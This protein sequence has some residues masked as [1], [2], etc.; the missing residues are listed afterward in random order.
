[1]IEPATIACIAGDI[2]LGSSVTQ[3]ELAPAAT[4]SQQTRQQRVTMFGS[5]VMAAARDVVTDHP[6]DRLRSLPIEITLVC[7]GLQRQPLIAWLP[8]APGVRADTVIA[9]ND[10][11]PPIGVGA[12]VDRVGDHPVDAG[13][14]WSTPDDV[15][16]GWPCRQIQVVL[17]EPKQR[18]TGA[19]EFHHLGEDQG[20][21]LL[22]TPVGIFLEPIARLHEADWCRHD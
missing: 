5:A 17:V 11:G 12:T 16:V 18:L 22:N 2:V 3:R 8:A 7:V 13:V 14:A 15:T 20:D 10:T 9:G 6:A 4:T 21:C 19:A 1:M